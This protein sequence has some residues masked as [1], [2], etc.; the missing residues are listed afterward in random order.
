MFLSLPGGRRLFGSPGGVWV[1]GL[2]QTGWRSVVFIRLPLLL[3]VQIKK[4]TELP[5]SASPPPGSPPVCPFPPVSASL[6][7]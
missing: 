6:T 1:G 5:L 4:G 3:L 2:D 7:R